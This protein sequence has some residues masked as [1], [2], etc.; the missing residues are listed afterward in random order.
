MNEKSI[1]LAAAI[2][3]NFKLDSRPLRIPLFWV[4]QC[5]VCGE[6]EGEGF[7]PTECA[8]CGSTNITARLGRL[9]PTRRDVPARTTAM[10]ET[11]QA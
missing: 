11:E 4:T 9:L 1:E 6:S 7:E 10:G 3:Q 2:A 5:P 8:F